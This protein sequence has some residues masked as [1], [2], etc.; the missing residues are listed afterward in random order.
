MDLLRL[1]RAAPELLP[2]GQLG[3]SQERNAAVAQEFR[4]RAQ[5]RMARGELL[6]IDATL[7][8]PGDVAEWVAL[9]R[10]FRYDVLVADFSAMSLAQA[11]AQNLAR[12][13]LQQ[14]P[15]STL[16]RMHRQ[17]S[18]PWETAG[19]EVVRWAPGV[20]MA[21]AVAAWLHVPSLDLSHYRA[22]VHI[23][24]LQGCLTVLTGPDGPLAEG[25]R[26]DVAYFFVGDLL[27]RGPE[28]AEVFAWFHEHALPRAN[29]F[30]LWGN[31]EDHLHRWA[32]GLPPVSPEFEARTLP[33]LLAAGARPE[34]AENICRKARDVVA[35]TWR[36]NRVLVCHAGLSTVPERLAAIS[37]HQYS[38]GTGHWQDP[39]DAQFHRNAPPGW[40]QV[41]GHRN[42]GGV[43]V[44]ASP[45]SFNLEDSVEHGGHLRTVTLD[46]Q[47]W[48]GGEFRN[49][50][51]V[52][53]R[54]R[55]QDRR[56]ERQ[57]NRPIPPPA[58]AD[59][60]P[61]WMERPSETRMDDTTLAAMRTHPGVRE[62]SSGAAPHV[63]ALNFTKQVFFQASWDDVL[64]RARGL[65]LN[66]TS[67]EIVARGYEKFFNV[68]ERPETRLSSLAQSLQWPVTAYVKENGFLGN[69][70]YDA[71][72]DELFVASK[73]TPD[74]DFARW[75]REIFEATVPS[76]QRERLRRWLRDNEASMVF[77]VID[78]VNDPHMIDYDRAHLVL[79]DVFHRGTEPEKLPYE[80]LVAVAERFG[81]TAKRRA[82]EFRTAQALRGWH[83][84]ACADLSWR[85]RGEDIE[86]LV[87]ED[88][89]GFQTKVKLPHYAFWKRMRSAKERLAEALRQLES[90]ADD[91]AL[92]RKTAVLAEM[93]EHKEVLRSHQGQGP[94][95]D[96]ARACLRDLGEELAPLNAVLAGQHRRERVI[97]QIKATCGRDPHPLAQAF[98]GWCVQ[99]RAATLTESSILQ[100]RTAFLA[101]TA[102]EQVREAMKVPWVGF[103]DTD[104]PEPQLETGSTP[105]PPARRR[106][107]P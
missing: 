95:A 16:E 57:L 75:F 100:L 45:R 32:Q 89:V 62:R 30:L 42:H 46:E 63:A 64:V 83:A 34:Q 102:P 7:T 14:V 104:P 67:Q 61:A 50:R 29:V 53:A 1:V 87:L 81:L 8:L 2:T 37:S 11:Q 85:F 91:G 70:G 38:R 13:P 40:F 26:D 99:Q 23:G 96:A 56:M 103:D 27:D 68:G 47:G 59:V 31:H 18:L 90:L 5:E 101:S 105:V 77:E 106:P 69:L 44:Q 80:H 86:G 51:F 17:I 73:S 88:S 93:A 20:N 82:M 98:L 36:G 58:L 22:V 107:R 4:M 72:T 84:A 74:G 48:T 43:A 60:P 55:R 65:F 49:R 15:H 3:V 21:P 78:P 97:E 9:A 12:D 19:A 39:V 94:E 41:H 25:F 33:Q 28:N 66:R 35:Y 52:S 71:H 6:A 54:Q 24:D 76:E 10:S 79:L 92:A